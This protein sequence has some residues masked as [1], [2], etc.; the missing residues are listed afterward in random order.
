[1]AAKRLEH[2]MAEE[3]KFRATHG[4]RG[5]NDPV[6]VPVQRRYQPGRA[7]HGSRCSDGLR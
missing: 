2:E 6:P 5:P 7:G 1:V 3:A 4:G